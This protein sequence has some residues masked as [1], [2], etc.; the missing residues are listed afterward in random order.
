M[1]L[2]ENNAE[3][4]WGGMADWYDDLV[5]G[6]GSYQR[7]LVLPNLM[8]LLANTGEAGKNGDMGDIRDIGFLAGLRILDLACGQGFFSRAFARQGANVTG[9]DISPELIELAKKNSLRLDYHVSSAESLTFLRSG[10]FDIVSIVLAIQ[11]IEHFGLVFAECARVLKPAGRLLLILNHPAFRIPKQSSWGFDEKQN[12]QYRRLDGY[13]GES[14]V[15]IDMKPGGKIGPKTNEEKIGTKNNEKTISFHRPLQAYFKALEK[16]GFQVKRLEE[17]TSHKVSQS[18]PR[19]AAEN[20]A[21][22]EFPLFM[23]IEAIKQEVTK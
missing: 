5:E 12:V 22:N 15:E 11:N 21:R 19:Q 8:R 10:E 3:T 2:S 20:R 6:D 23:M 18:G 7:E 1:K 14:K 9:V 4:S 13:L 16:N 17:W